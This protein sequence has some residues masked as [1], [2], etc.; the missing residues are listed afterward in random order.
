LK[1]YS[2]AIEAYKKAVK[3]K[4]NLPWVHM[5]LGNALYY[6]KRYDGAIKAYKNASKINP[7]KYTAYANKRIE[8][9]YRKM[10]RN[11][12]AETASQKVP[13]IL[14]DA[15]SF[16]NI[17]NDYLQ[18]EEYEEAI[19]AFRIAVKLDANHVDALEG[20]ALTYLKL[21]RYEEAIAEYGK[22]IEI[23]PDN[24]DA[25][26]DMGDVLSIQN[27]YL[28]AIKAYK[29][30]VEIQ[31]DFAAAYNAYVKLIKSKYNETSEAY[32]E[33]IRNNP[34]DIAARVELAEFYLIAGDFSGA[35]KTANE[36][37]REEEV[38]GRR[39]GHEYR[40]AMIFVYI[41]SSFL[42][43]K[44]P[45]AIAKT[46]QFFK[47]YEK[48]PGNYRGSWSYAAGKR[49]ISQDR[50]LT[51]D[52]KQL[53]LLVIEILE[54]PKSVGVGKFPKLREAIQAVVISGDS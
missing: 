21:K 7:R 31:P 4:H 24:A 23:Q 17:G 47:A 11:D 2:R 20:L 5:E 46:S 48:L 35:L 44:R 45:E 1:Q 52:Q 9:V 12:A 33:A 29:K 19:K 27:K 37:L 6:M 43:G 28:E 3:I 42:S 38:T 54:S 16:C 30:A 10:G 15:D 22:V 50:R 40:M 14:Q 8:R 39:I 34:P 26:K 13:G 18:E 36:L 49:F 51:P 32:L 41:S 53:L 25:Y